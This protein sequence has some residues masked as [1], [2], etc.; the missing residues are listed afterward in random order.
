MIT[1][2]RNRLAICNWNVERVQPNSSKFEQISKECA[3][4]ESDIW[5]LTESHDKLVPAE[6]FFS[7]FSGI[8]DRESKSGERLI[9][10]WSRWP[11]FSLNHYVTDKSRGAAGL[12]TDSPFGSLV[13]YGLVLPWGGDKRTSDNG[14]FKAYQLALLEIKLD[15][16]RLKAEYPNSSLVVAGDFNQSLVDVPYYGSKMKRASLEST[17]QEIGL[18]AL[19]SGEKDPIYRDSK[20]Y[21]CIDHIFISKNDGWN[22]EFTERWPD[23]PNLEKAPSDHFLVSVNLSR[24][25]INA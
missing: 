20:P 23:A 19:T 7:T 4:K 24:T 16:M 17:F 3:G 12:I 5:F 13:L 18:I 9:S 22:L 6:R 21:A 1:Q 10:L 8:P 11:I 14:N 2:L 15:L 25:P